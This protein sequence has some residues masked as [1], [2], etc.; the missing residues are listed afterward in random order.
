[1][2]TVEVRRTVRRALD[3]LLIRFVP[4]D[5]FKGKGKARYRGRLYPSPFGNLAKV[6]ARDGVALGG[7]TFFHECIHGILLFMP[8]HFDADADHEGTRWRGWTEE[9][10][11][12][13]RY[14][15]EEFSELVVGPPI[16]DK[17]KP[18]AVTCASCDQN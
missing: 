18:H 17:L 9:V 13:E 15:N 10:T 16:D 6:A 8:P 7:T 5:S 14:L 12:L 2:G 4:G 1:M 3:S 11:E